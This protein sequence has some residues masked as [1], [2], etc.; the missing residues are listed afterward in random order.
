VRIEQHTEIVAKKSPD[1]TRKDGV[2][3][4]ALLDAI[5]T[6]RAAGIPDGASIRIEGNGSTYDRVIRAY[7]T[8]ER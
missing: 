7:W 1:G 8:E 6:M 4:D 5:T 2:R 3:L